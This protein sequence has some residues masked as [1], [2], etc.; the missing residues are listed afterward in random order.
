MDNNVKC[1]LENLGNTCYLNAALQCIAPTTNVVV[2][3]L[4]LGAKWRVENR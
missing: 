1:G 3:L 2:L 4:D